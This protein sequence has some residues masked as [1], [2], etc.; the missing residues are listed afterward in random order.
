MPLSQR[1]DSGTHMT[2]PYKYQLNSHIHCIS[3]SNYYS[4]IKSTMDT[5]NLFLY[6]AILI[7]TY[8]IFNNKIRSKLNNLPPSPFLC[9]PIIGHLYL[10]KKPL[11]R[12]LDRVSN[13]YGPIIKNKGKYG[14]IRKIRINTKVN[15]KIDE[16]LK[17]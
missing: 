10:F 17:I 3:L 4:T 12:S 15:R 1:L 13:R 8:L 9:F 7:I 5:I 6:L 11:H 2:Y 16:K 14:K